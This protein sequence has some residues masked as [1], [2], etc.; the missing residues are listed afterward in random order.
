MMQF[1]YPKSDEDAPEI[2]KIVLTG[3]PCSGKTT[4]LAW[5]DAEFSRRGWT[6][7][8]VS[9][10]ATTVAQG[11]ASPHDFSDRGAG[12][13]AMYFKQI[14]DEEFYERIACMNASP[15][16]KVLIVCDR[17]ALDAFAFLSL[18]DRHNFMRLTGTTPRKMMERYD[19]VFHLVSAAIGAEEFYTVS[20]NSAR[21]ET[22][23][24][25]AV[26]DRNVV[27]AWTGHP[28]LRIIDNSTDFHNKMLRLIKEVAV[29][30]GEPQPYEVERKYLIR[31]PAEDRLSE[32]TSD[33]SQIVQIYLTPPEGSERRIRQRGAQ[34]AWTYTLT[35]KRT[36]ESSARR[37]E[38]EKR[39][40]EKDYVDLLAEADPALHPIRKKRWCIPYES[41]YFEID[42][43]PFS[44]EFAIMEVELPDEDVVFEMPPFVEVIREV[45]A[46]SAYK[47]H[48][49]ARNPVLA[50]RPEEGQDDAE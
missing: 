19:G 3:G 22:L 38:T 28:H 31:K 6:V 41:I 42:V 36:T 15:D 7:Y 46:E 17:G 30:T 32:L 24:E 9:E 4:A 34:G 14:A 48:N 33:C 45:T 26:V 23:E 20:N 43:Y 10:A 44:D 37:I 29:V 35:T 25:A 2:T 12:Q 18:E 13:A 39:L 49:L 21:R 50:E 40:T 16:D 47:N 11:N 8:I 1:P 27:A 5:I